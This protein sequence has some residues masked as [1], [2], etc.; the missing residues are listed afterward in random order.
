MNIPLQIKIKT[1]LQSQSRNKIVFYKD[2][3]FDFT[4]VNVGFLLS[5]LIYNWTDYSKLS[6]K[7]TTELDK[8]LNDA[9]INHSNFGRMIAISNIGIL[10]EPELKQNLRAILEN[11]S[12]NNSLFVQWDGDI[13]EQNLYFITKE[14]GIKININEISHIAI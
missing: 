1:F 8:I 6:M 11:Y 7:V 12:N 3:L 2:L 9:V 13:D 4:P 14:K 10:F 5:Q